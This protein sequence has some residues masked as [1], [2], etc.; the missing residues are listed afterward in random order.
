MQSRTLLKRIKKGKVLRVYFE[1][2]VDLLT[3]LG[4]ERGPFSESYWIYRH[5]EVPRPFP[6]Q[7]DG[8]FI[9]PFQIRQLL[10]LLETYI[11][12]QGCAP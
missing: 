9:R 4:F 8:E 5:P 10:R 12:R 2:F 11:P 1:D 6:V 3:D 7:L